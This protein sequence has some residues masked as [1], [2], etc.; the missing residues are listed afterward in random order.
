MSKSLN[1]V[2]MVSGLLAGCGQKEKPSSTTDNNSSGNPITAPV[3]Y[4]G[5]V[6]KAQK[7]A[8]KVVDL[9]SLKNAIHLFHAQED[10]YPANL[11]EL[12]SMRYIADVPSAPAGSQLSYNPANGEVKFVKAQ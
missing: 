5:A 4:L 12:V 9:A 11:Q 1:M 10:R 8:V 7:T 6:N 3:D 2:L